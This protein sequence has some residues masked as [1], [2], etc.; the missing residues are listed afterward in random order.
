MSDSENEVEKPHTGGIEKILWSTLFV[1]VLESV[2]VRYSEVCR[3][4]HYQYR[5]SLFA[6]TNTHCVSRQT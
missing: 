4:V 5:Y 2:T 1:I 3:K 6:I